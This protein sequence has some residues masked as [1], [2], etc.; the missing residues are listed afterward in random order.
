MDS[1]MALYSLLL[2]DQKLFDKKR[3]IPWSEFLFLSNTEFILDLSI[4][5]SSKRF[6]GSFGGSGGVSVFARRV[7]LDLWNKL[8]EYKAGHKVSAANGK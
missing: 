3:N 6:G 4:K 5:I 7:I 2:L 8:V 1:A